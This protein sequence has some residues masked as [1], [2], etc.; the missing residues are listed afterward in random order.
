MTSTSLS[1]VV[2]A[3]QDQ[4]KLKGGD[5]RKEYNNRTNVSLSKPLSLCLN[6]CVF[7]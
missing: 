2:T 4:N 6:Q 5:F 7:I 3:N 1:G